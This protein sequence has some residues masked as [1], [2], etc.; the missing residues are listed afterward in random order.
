M[1]T[2]N[3]Y[4]GSPHKNPVMMTLWKLK[5]KTRM[6]GLSAFK[7]E[8]GNYLWNFKFEQGFF[9]LIFQIRVK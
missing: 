6:K 2:K 5:K 8:M 9:Y 1:F 3:V 7:R 4:C